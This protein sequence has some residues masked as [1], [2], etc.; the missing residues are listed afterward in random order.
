MKADFY[1]KLANVEKLAN[2]TS[3][4]KEQLM[5]DA[6]K[7]DLLPSVF[8]A[9]KVTRNDKE[10]LK[11]WDDP[12]NIPGPWALIWDVQPYA[13]KLISDLVD[14]GET[15]VREFEKKITED[16]LRPE[17]WRLDKTARR[18]ITYPIVNGIIFDGLREVIQ[19]DPFPFDRCSIC[20]Q[21]FVP[22]K[23]QKYCSKSC[24]TK[25]LA[26]WKAKY[27]KTYMSERR[28]IE[29]KGS[30]SRRQKKRA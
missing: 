22:G 29:K 16:H 28:E 1:A 12:K 14:R 8:F 26:P 13:R 23:N 27:M 15:D 30:R 4:E 2:L 9:M 19:S 24:A 25:A 11:S 20:T 3:A 5:V 18:V 21:F 7:A 10:F 17:I 6:V